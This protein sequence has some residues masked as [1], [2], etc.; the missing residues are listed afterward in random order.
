MPQPADNAQGSVAF[1]ISRPIGS[2]GSRFGRC[3]DFDPLPQ[4]D[5][6]DC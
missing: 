3:D 5:H 1:F 2:G 6:P 4:Q